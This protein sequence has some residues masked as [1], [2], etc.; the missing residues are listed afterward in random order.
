[1]TI[2]MQGPWT[3]SVKFKES[4][5]Q[6][7]FVIAGATSGNGTYA[8]LVTT[9]P[10]SVIGPNWA[11]TIQNNP[12]TGWVNSDDQIKFPTLSV[13]QYR[14]DIQSNDQG[15]DQDFKHVFLKPLQSGVDYH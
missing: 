11:I 6:Q 9:P 10:V 15:A 14:F 2:T 12:G 5:F 3:V 13:G 7:R 4:A 8:G 1:M